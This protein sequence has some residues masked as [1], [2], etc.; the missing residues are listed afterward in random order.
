MIS[1]YNDLGLTESLK[2][3]LPKYRIKEQYNYAKTAIFISLG[4]QIIT[5]LII[6]IILWLVAP[7]L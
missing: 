3:F 7:W 1:I 5:A 6:I 2:Y 4:V